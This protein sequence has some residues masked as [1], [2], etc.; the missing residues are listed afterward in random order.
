MS[1]SSVDTR[2]DYPPSIDEDDQKIEWVTTNGSSSSPHNNGRIFSMNSKSS[3]FSTKSKGDE[4]E[5][6]LDSIEIISDHSKKY[7]NASTWRDIGLLFSQFEEKISICVNGMKN[8]MAIPLDE[9]Q[10]F[11]VKESK[12]IS[13]TLRYIN[14]RKTFWHHNEGWSHSPSSVATEVPEDPSFRMFMSTN[15]IFCNPAKSVTLSIIAAFGRRVQKALF[16][17]KIPLKPVAP[18]MAP[19]A[20]SVHG[21]L[22]AKGVERDMEP[23]GSIQYYSAHQAKL[24]AKEKEKEKQLDEPTINLEL[25]ITCNFG[26]HKRAIRYS[27]EG[28]YHHLIYYIKQKFKKQVNNVWYYSIGKQRWVPLAEEEDWKRAKAELL[29]ADSIRLNLFIR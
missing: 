14:F 2:P 8:E 3:R 17:R 22:G 10:T 1:V 11:S 29:R 12:I 7:I 6:E 27:T 9:I 24:M 13:I 21:C 16:S 18:E 19:R 28:S 5:I 4:D 23:R 26:D 20:L 15:Q 25:Y